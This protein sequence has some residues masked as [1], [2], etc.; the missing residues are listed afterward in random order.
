MRACNSQ[1]RTLRIT[2]SVRQQL[3]N[4]VGLLIEGKS[5]DCNDALRKA[6]EKVKPSPSIFV[7]DTISRNAEASG[8]VADVII[9]DNLEKRH[10]SASRISPGER[11][12]LRLKNAPG[13]IDADAW[14]VIRSAIQKRKSMVMVEGE[15]DL[16]TLVA[17]VLAPLGSLVA[18]GQPDRGIVIVVVSDAEKSLAEKII[19]GLCAT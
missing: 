13:T 15:E 8:I 16:L 5:V 14:D 3:K 1:L 9:V 11:N 4:P 17:V 6:V 2:N 10:E 12:I 18:Y 19:R 7:G